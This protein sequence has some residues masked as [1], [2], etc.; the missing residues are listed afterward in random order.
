MIKWMLYGQFIS[1]SIKLWVEPQHKKTQPLGDAVMQCVVS[2]YAAFPTCTTLTTVCISRFVQT[3]ARTRWSVM[4]YTHTESTWWCTTLTYDTIRYW[5]SCWRYCR[6]Q[7]I[8][9]WVMSLGIVWGEASLHLKF[10]SIFSSLIMASFS[11][12][13]AEQLPLRSN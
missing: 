13:V 7:S 6:L 5:A 2:L 10:R 1:L 3:V 12:W 4:N 9:M 11:R 8:A